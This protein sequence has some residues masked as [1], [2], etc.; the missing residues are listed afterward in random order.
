MSLS[1]KKDRAGFVGE[2]RHVAVRVC[3]SVCVHTYRSVRG[4]LSSARHGEREGDEISFALCARACV[5]EPL[6]RLLASA[7]SGARIIKTLLPLLGV[8]T[9]GELL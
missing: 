7:A 5:P 6:L 8:I 2:R 4:A 3:A 1:V 9:T